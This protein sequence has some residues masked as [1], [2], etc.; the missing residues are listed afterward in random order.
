MTKTSGQK[1][2]NLQN[3]KT[4]QHEIKSILHHFKGISAARNYLR[5]EIG[6]LTSAQ[7]VTFL[8]PGNEKIGGLSIHEKQNGRLWKTSS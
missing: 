4:S 2:K 8:I 3:E 1:L 6:L 5:S 7:I